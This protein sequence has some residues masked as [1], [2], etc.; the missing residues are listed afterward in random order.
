MTDID[1]SSWW[2]VYILE[3]MMEKSPQLYFSITDRFSYANKYITVLSIK[4]IRN[5]AVSGE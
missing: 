4:R 2:T 1:V 5:N 3:T